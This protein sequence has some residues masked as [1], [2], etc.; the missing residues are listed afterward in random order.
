MGEADAPPAPKG[1][2]TASSSFAAKVK[3]IAWPSICENEPPALALVEAFGLTKI[4]APF[5]AE[6]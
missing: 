5:P 3:E 1:L 2:D 6:D 4:T